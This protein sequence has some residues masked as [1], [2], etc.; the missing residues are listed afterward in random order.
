MHKGIEL[1]RVLEELL[2][3][4]CNFMCSKP[5]SKNVLQNWLRPLAHEI[6][7]RIEIW[8]T[9]LMKEVKLENFILTETD[10][11]ENCKI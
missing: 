9:D 2:V 11:V 1:N 4:V 6:Q 3:A 7:L 5:Q 8:V 10:E